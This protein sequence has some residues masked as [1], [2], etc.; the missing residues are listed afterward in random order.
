MASRTSTLDALARFIGLDLRAALAERAGADP[1]PVL[2]AHVDET[3]RRVPAY[4]A[5]LAEHGVAHTADFA[6]LPIASKENYV[7]RYPLAER[8]LDGTLTTSDT[9][10]VSSGSTGEPAIWPRAVADELQVAERFEQVFLNFAADRRRTLAVVCFPLGT[11]VGGMFTAACLRHLAVKGYPVV[12]A[13]PGNQRAEI[14]RVLRELAAGFDQVVLLGYPP[15]LKDVIDHGPAA[16]IAWAAMAIKMVFAGEVFSEEWR[17]LVAERAGVADPVRD[18]AALYGTADGGVLA[19]ETPAA[20]AVRRLLSARPEAAR[21][22]FGEGRLP[23]FAQYDPTQRWFEL[24]GSTLTFSGRGGAPLVRYNILD[25]GGIMSWPDLRAFLRGVDP[26]FEL[27]DGA[28]RL[29][30]VWVFGRGHLAVSF[31]GA[32]VFP[33]MIARGLEHPDVREWATGKFVVSVEEDAHH[34]VTLH[35]AVELAAR[36]VESDARRDAAAAA[37]ASALAAQSSEYA[38]Y[39]PA[40]R[41]APRV[42]LWPEG[43]PEHFPI[44]VKHRYVRH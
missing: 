42:T 33:E 5:F 2:R 3:I 1:T 26:A 41:R 16:G 43:H 9:I 30:F 38:A 40:A 13:T 37:I 44:G 36:Q 28:P 23:T 27:D 25:T 11:W 20:I 35:V 31:Y 22:L 18:T 8:C 19:C 29:P 17:T 34:D 24:A 6:Q 15:F 7:R 4:R 14:Y 32:N 10:A 39:V 12:V 21:A